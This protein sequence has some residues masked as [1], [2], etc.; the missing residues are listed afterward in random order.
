MSDS[1][2]RSHNRSKNR[3]TL[4]ALLALVAF[5]FVMTVIATV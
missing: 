2:Q 1:A 5:L 3:M 4:W